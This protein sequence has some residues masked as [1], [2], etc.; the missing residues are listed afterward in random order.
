MSQKIVTSYEDLLYDIQTYKDTDN[1]SYPTKTNLLP[2]DSSIYDVDLNARLINVPKMLSVQFDHNAEVVFFKA[3]RYHDNVDLTNTVCIIEYVNANGD[4][5][6]YWVPYY[7][8]EHYD[9][10]VDADGNE[11][12]V[13]VMY[14]PWAIGGL[15]TAYSGTIT[16]SI[17]F[18]KLASDKTYMY[19]LSTQPAQSQILHGMDLI[20]DDALEAFKL[21]SS[22][23]SQIYN[24][25]AIGMTNATTYWIDL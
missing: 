9:I 10:E 18:Y 11:T 20:D 23:V 15:A 3:H 21:E 7:D 22:V 13:P 14:F 16:F 4:P 24:N 2:S 17:R 5:G 1:I 25:L 6:L 19:N 8:V 12:R